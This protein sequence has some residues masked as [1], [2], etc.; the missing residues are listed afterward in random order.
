MTPEQ[1]DTLV[2]MFQ[3]GMACG[4]NHPFEFFMNYLRTL[5]HFDYKK[6]P[7]LER[8]AYEAML[9]FMKGCAGCEEEQ[10]FYNNLDVVSLNKYIDGWYRGYQKRMLKWCEENKGS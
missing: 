9:E 6:V 4:L 2:G 8:K 3:I 10:E 5:D 1:K 7:E